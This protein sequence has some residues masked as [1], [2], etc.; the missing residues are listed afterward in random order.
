[1]LLSKRKIETI[2]SRALGAQILASEARDENV[3]AKRADFFSYVRLLFTFQ[4]LENY[5]STIKNH[6]DS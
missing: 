4:G 1:M 5:F 2:R 6:F 3:R